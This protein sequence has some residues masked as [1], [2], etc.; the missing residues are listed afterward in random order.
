MLSAQLS[1][2]ISPEHLWLGLAQTCKNL[3]F[4]CGIYDFPTSPLFEAF[5]I[6]NSSTFAGQ[7]DLNNAWVRLLTKLSDFVK[8]ISFRDWASSPEGILSFFSHQCFSLPSQF[9]YTRSRSPRKLCGNIYCHI[10][11]HAH[12]FA[13]RG[14]L[15]LWPG[16]R[17]AFT[18][19]FPATSSFHPLSTAPAAAG[20]INWVILPVPSIGTIFSLLLPASS[21]PLPAFSAKFPA[22]GPFT[23][24]CW[25][26]LVAIL[27]TACQSDQT[28]FSAAATISSYHRKFAREGGSGFCLP[29]SKSG[30]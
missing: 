11:P 7:N 23:R 18:S 24:S 21:F 14:P 15:F 9:A 3:P 13:A 16:T 17:A 25:S 2:K 12:S 1:I 8:W 10:F 19:I 27:V 26:D 30:F 22:P 29:E 20:F 4:R 6:F 5:P 28:G